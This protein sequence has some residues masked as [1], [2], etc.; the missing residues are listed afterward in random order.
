MI[1]LGFKEKCSTGNPLILA[2]ARWRK[3][4]GRNKIRGKSHCLSR[5]R[6]KRNYVIGRTNKAGR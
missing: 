1:L 4:K 3:R 2:A 5:A 6:M